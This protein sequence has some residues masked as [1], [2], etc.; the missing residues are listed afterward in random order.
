VSSN[1]CTYCDVFGYRH[2]VLPRIA[3]PQ[4][5][6]NITSNVPLAWLYAVNRSRVRTPSS[7]ILWM[8]HGYSRIVASPFL[9][10]P[11]G[12]HIIG[13]QV[14]F[15][16][17][18][19]PCCVSQFSNPY[20]EWPS[21]FSPCFFPVLEVTISA[22]KTSTAAILV[23]LFAFYAETLCFWQ[24]VY[25]HL[26]SLRTDL[27]PRKPQLTGALVSPQ[28][29]EP[30]LHKFYSCLVPRLP[31]P[32][33]HIEYCIISWLLSQAFRG[34]ITLTPNLSVYCGYLNTYEEIE[35]IKLED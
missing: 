31:I 10:L 8:C 16:C 12:Y 23:V 26:I 11:K 19:V 25:L 34:M 13:C 24:Q 20:M 22:P 29:R 28:M 21:V 32:F 18:A 5:P 33:L 27:L 9:L 4:G 3:R 17:R 1:G 14:G 6:D 15:Y 2:A 35:K 7:K 30:V